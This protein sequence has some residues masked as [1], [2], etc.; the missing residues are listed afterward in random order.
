[1]R[2]KTTQRLKCDRAVTHEYFCT[3]LRALV[4]QRSVH[5]LDTF[6]LKLLYV[7]L[8]EIGVLVFNLNLTSKLLFVPRVRT[9]FGSRSFAVA[10]PTI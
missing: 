8:Y 7:G 9:C 3:E 6:L 1:M 5:N 10:A 4:E 2:L